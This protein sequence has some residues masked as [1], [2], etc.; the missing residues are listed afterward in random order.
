MVVPKAL[1]LHPHADKPTGGT[2][3]K[4]QIIFAGEGQGDSIP[5]ALYLM[6]PMSP[7]NTTSKT[8]LAYTKI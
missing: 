3:Y 7:Y 6:N 1:S 4:D 2:N 5:S 8:L